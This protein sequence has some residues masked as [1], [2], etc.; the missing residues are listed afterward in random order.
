MSTVANIAIERIKRTIC[1]IEYFGSVDVTFDSEES[2]KSFIENTFVI[3]HFKNGGKGEKIPTA[4][5]TEDFEFQPSE[6]LIIRCP[7]SDEDVIGIEV[8]TASDEQVF[9]FEV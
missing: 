7:V 3:K 1:S 9:Y 5:T 2:K 8:V 6:L 4:N